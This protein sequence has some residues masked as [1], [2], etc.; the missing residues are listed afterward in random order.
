MTVLLSRS[1]LSDF[2]PVITWFL[3]CRD[4]CIYKLWLM[5]NK[6]KFARHA[7]YDEE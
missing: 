5:V 3:S 2:F 1:V 7:K 4:N 6:V